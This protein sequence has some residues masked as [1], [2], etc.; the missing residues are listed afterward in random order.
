M[1]KCE[2]TSMIK[3]S[4]QRSAPSAQVL[5]RSA[6]T[7]IVV[8]GLSLCAPIIWADSGP[9]SSETN[10]PNPSPYIRAV[11]DAQTGVVRLE[12]ASRCL[13]PAAGTGT[14]VWLVGTSH[15]AMKDYYTATQ[16]FLDS[17]PLV[18][19]EDV[20]GNNPEATN[21]T[22]AVSAYQ[23]ARRRG[24]ATFPKFARMHGLVSQ[25]ESINYQRPNFEFCDLTP[26]QLEA[27]LTKS[28]GRPPTVGMGRKS[29]EANPPAQVR[30]DAATQA[31]L[32]KLGQDA[33]TQAMMMRLFMIES[34]K[35]GA[36]PKD[37]PGMEGFQ[38][39]TVNQRN[40]LILDR[41]Q[42][43]LQAP[44]PASELA[45]F[46][47]AG[48]LPFLEQQLGQKLNFTVSE[49]KWLT[50]LTVGPSDLNVS[51]EEFRLLRK[52]VASQVATQPSA[53]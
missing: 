45:V 33:K 9:V 16:A 49:E 40:A 36:L 3:F 5:I 41:I 10:R 27:L 24:L 42:K 51:I 20:G 18:L 11:E 22:T 14:R 29:S 44:Q 35:D 12:F 26:S 47:G 43:H 23:V 17:I 13:A 31:V 37:T 30:V 38:E 28:M 8:A 34:S 46:Y 15:M 19:F 21:T 2:L 25:A 1:K 39:V 32:S 50:A 48:H 53:P 6:V 52:F 7:R 4:F